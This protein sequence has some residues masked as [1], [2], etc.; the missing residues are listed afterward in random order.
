MSDDDQTRDEIYAIVNDGPVQE[1][2]IVTLLEL[3]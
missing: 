1:A 2:V 3:L